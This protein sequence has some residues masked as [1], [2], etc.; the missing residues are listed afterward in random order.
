M[1]VLRFSAVIT[2]FLFTI[3]PAVLGFI[4]GGLFFIYHLVSHLGGELHLQSALQMWLLTILHG[5]VMYAIP[6]FVLGL[7]M[8]FLLDRGIAKSKFLVVSLLSAVAMTIWAMTTVE[9]AGPAI[10][11]F[12]IAFVGLCIF[13]PWVSI[14]MEQR[15]VPRIFNG[16]K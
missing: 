15:T 9:F 14:P 1:R 12:I 4:V 10:V 6:C 7:I 13:L 16:A 5:A 8:M 3:L 11:I 2:V